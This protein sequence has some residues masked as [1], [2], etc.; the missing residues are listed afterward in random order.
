M[1][2]GHMRTILIH[3][4]LY[5]IVKEDTNFIRNSPKRL[6]KHLKNKVTKHYSNFNSD[7]LLLLL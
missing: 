1:G 5:L 4:I 6:L 2:R 7:I 3:N